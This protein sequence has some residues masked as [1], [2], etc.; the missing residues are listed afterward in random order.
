[1]FFFW[2]LFG[3]IYLGGLGSFT[4]R[5]RGVGFL[6]CVYNVGGA[7]KKRL[8]CLWHCESWTRNKERERERNEIENLLNL[9]LSLS[10]NWSV[11]TGE[12]INAHK[13]Y[14]KCSRSAENNK[15]KWY[16]TK[17]QRQNAKHNT[18]WANKKIKCKTRI[19][20]KTLGW[21]RSRDRAGGTERKNGRVLRRVLRSAAKA[22]Q[23]F[24]S[25]FPFLIL[26][27]LQFF[28][29]SLFEL[30][31]EISAWVFKIFKVFEFIFDLYIFVLF[32]SFSFCLYRARYRILKT[33]AD[34]HLRIWVRFE[35]WIGFLFL[36]STFSPT[37]V[38]ETRARVGVQQNDRA[39]WGI[40]RSRSCEARALPGRRGIPRS[41]N[42]KKKTIS[43]F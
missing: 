43:T 41:L 8:R 4:V 28:C 21:E 32:F 38:L 36:L 5:I 29:L 10:R 34:C 20:Q 14:E 24:L 7:K 23:I 19:R 17:S 6:Y 30:T 16:E 13:L 2:L 22:L 33:F 27:N 3:Y 26:V 11:G 35:I 39:L 18:K 25:P 9:K 40:A 15:N 1:M 12:I 42:Q 31:G 37:T